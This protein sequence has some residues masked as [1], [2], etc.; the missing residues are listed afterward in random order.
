MIGPVR[1]VAARYLTSD[2]RWQIGDIDPLNAA[3]AAFAIDQT[4]PGGFDA[5]AERRYHAESCNDHSSHLRLP[6]G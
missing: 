1:S 2:T 3:D 4:A 6:S 5:A